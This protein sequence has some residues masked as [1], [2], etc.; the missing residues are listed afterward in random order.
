MNRTKRSRDTKGLKVTDILTD[1]RGHLH[2]VACTGKHAH[3]P[4]S[5]GIA[6]SPTWELGMAVTLPRP[7]CP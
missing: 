7:S 3:I 2:M 6:E 1:T 5:Q 4:M